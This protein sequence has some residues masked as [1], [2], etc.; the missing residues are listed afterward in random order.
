LITQI[1]KRRADE[2]ERIEKLKAEKQVA[3]KENDE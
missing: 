1:E 3:E 2:K